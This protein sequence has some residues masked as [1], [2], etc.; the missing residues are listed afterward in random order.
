MRKAGI[1]LAFALWMQGCGHKGPLTLPPAAK[2]L[3]ANA[4]QQP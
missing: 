3:P 1:I 2:Q 4:Q